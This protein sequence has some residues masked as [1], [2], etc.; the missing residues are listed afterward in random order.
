MCPRNPRL[1]MINM[2]QSTSLIIPDLQDALVL[3]DVQVRHHLGVPV[4]EGP[5]PGA[6]PDHQPR[7]VG[8]VRGE[9]RVVLHVVQ[10]VPG[11]GGHE[12]G[13]TAHIQQPGHGVNH[14]L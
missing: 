12:V 1:L 13:D 6:R 11:H 2:I 4:D 10:L 3:V 7:G 5:G 8:L 9:L 14:H